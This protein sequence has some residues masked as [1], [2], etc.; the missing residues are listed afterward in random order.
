MDDLVGHRVRHRLPPPAPRQPGEL[1]PEVT[2]AVQLEHTPIRGRGAVEGDLPGE[3]DDRR[4]PAQRLLDRPWHE[5]AVGTDAFIAVALRQECHEQI[6]DQP[7]GRLGAGRDEEAEKAHHLF[8]VELLPV[9]GAVD[10]PSDEVVPWFG[11]PGSDDRQENF[12]LRHQASRRRT[13]SPAAIL[14]A[15]S[16]R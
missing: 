1:L 13:S 14:P 16:S 2:P 7:E 3:H 6:A 8:V 9:D 12:L 5:R 15:R 10:G 4:L 11:T